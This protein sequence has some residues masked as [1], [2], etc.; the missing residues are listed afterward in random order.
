MT[1]FSIQLSQNFLGKISGEMKVR[2][3]FTPREQSF[4]RTASLTEEQRE[5]ESLK[6]LKNDAENRGG[7]KGEDT[8]F[9]DAVKAAAGPGYVLM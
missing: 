4:R 5:A 8:H 9:F 6:L 3:L 2:F 7:K 1:A